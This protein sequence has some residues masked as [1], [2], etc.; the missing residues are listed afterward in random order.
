MLFRA[1]A[2]AAALLVGTYLAVPY[3]LR[4]WPFLIVTLGTLP[5][6]VAGLRR[7]PRG[8][9]TPWRLM[10]AAL[11]CYNVGNAI[12]IWLV[13]VEGRATGDGTVADLFLSGGG[14]LVL[15]GA[16]AVVVPRGRRDVG[17][18]IDAV[19]TGIALSG[20]LWT[21]V[22]LPVFQARHVSEGRQLAVFLNLF[23]LAGALGAMVRVSLL[24]EE[25]LTSVRFMTAGLGFAMLG[26]VSGELAFDA[27][28]LRADWTNAVYLAAYASFGLAALHPSVSAVTTP[29]RRPDDHLTRGR[30][31]FL[32]VMLALPPLAGGGRALLGLPVDGVLV[33][34]SA[35][36][37][38][39][40]VMI[41]IARLSAAR[42]AAEQ[43]LH[44]LATRDGLTGLPNR[45]ACLDRL[46]AELAAGGDDLA[47]LFGDLD[48]FKPVND[49]LGHAAGDELLVE[50]ASRLRTCIRDGDLVSRFGGDEFVIVCRGA[51]AVESVTARIRETFASPFTAGGEH[52][53]V[54]VSIG[55]SRATATVTTDELIGEADAAMYE[56]KKSRSR[57]RLEDAPDVLLR[58]APH[59][60]ILVVDDRPDPG[61]DAGA[62]SRLRGDDVGARS[63]L[64]GVDQA[65]ARDQ[66]TLVD[67][68]Q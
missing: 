3:E 45:G 6:V 65:G 47:V 21:V 59:A 30:L 16:I 57:T 2:V 43:A 46:T 28:G 19:I 66:E 13:T 27:N 61:D 50:V 34:F 42:R 58:L 20:L 9:R 63:R 15:A 62:R 33:A 55:V 14:V 60:R 35:A 26:S 31:A 39:P 18:L 4:H 67:L 12:W 10:V 23:V 52:V 44:R 22:L 38:T 1:Y 36:V 7:A 8:A 32:G 37:L 48:G 68:E 64:L 49:R 53:R 17:G 29:A 56:A 24:A 25:K 11:V 41:R 54:G 5:V 51:D 40:L